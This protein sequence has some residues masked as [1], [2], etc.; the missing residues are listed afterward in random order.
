V[1]FARRL[2]ALLDPEQNMLGI[3]AQ[4][5]DGRKEPFESL[6]EMA[7]HYLELIRTYQPSGPYYIGGPSL[8][9]KVC[10]EIA[11]QLVAGGEEPGMVVLFDTFAPGFPETKAPIRWLRDKL[12]HALE[13][14]WKNSAARL[15]Q[16]LLGRA[17]PRGY[18]DYQAAELDERFGATL[19]K[20][21]G[22]NQRASRSY[23]PQ[24]Y[25]GVITLFR[26]SQQP[27]WPGM[28][29]SDLTNGWKRFAAR[30]DVEVVDATHQHMFDEPA[31][32]E[33]VRKFSACQ[34][35]AYQRTALRV[36]RIST[37]GGT[38]TRVSDPSIPPRPSSQRPPARKEP[39]ET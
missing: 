16:R 33:L 9:G 28:D 18:V 12:A 25:P 11:Q 1:V 14:G 6:Q 30:V 8:G 32:Q 34:Q 19:R 7:R 17:T 36:S 3:Q 22:A 23:E 2:V 21:I 39:A 37:M 31:V 10:Y 35:R 4:G 26:A 29:F 27:N 15:G 20:V 38:P 13:D 24:P 5:L